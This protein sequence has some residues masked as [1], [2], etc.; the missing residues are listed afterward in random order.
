MPG[1]MT[2]SPSPSIPRTLLARIRSVLR[3]AR[4]P[5]ITF[6]G[7]I[8]DVVRRELFRPTGQ[9][10]ELTAGEFNIL[11]ALAS[12]PQEPLSRDFL[13]DVISNRDPREISSHTVDN[14]IARLRKKMTHEGLL[15]PSP[16]C[17]ASAMP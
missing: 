15:P 2:M 1:A 6:D 10:V 16:P 14:L 8:L 12:R 3:R 4:E 11:V 9:L 5:V 13:L 7:W 17:A